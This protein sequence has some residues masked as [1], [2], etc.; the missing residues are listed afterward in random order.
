MGLPTLA[1][2]D[3]ERLELP[4]RVIA[5]DWDGTAVMGR[6]EDAAEVC[7]LLVR[8]MRRDVTIVVITGTNLANTT[9]QLA[10]A[11]RDAGDHN[12]RLFIATNRGSE[13]YGFDGRG[14]PVPRFRRTASPEE[15][16]RLTAAVEAVRDQLRDRAGIE[17]RIVYDRLNRRKIDLIPLPEWA[18]PPKPEIGRLLDA[19]QSRLFAGGITGGLQEVLR[20]S[21]RAAAEAGLRDARVTSDVKHVEIGLTDKS[22][23]VEWMM[24]EVCARERV[25]PAQVLIA[26][27]EFGPIGGVEGSDHKMLTPGSREAVF[28]SVGP[29]PGGV[30]P[31]IL[32][33]GGGPARFRELLSEQVDFHE[34]RRAPRRE[35][36]A[37]ALLPLAA[38][39]TEADWTIVGEGLDLAREREAESVFAVGNGYLGTRA[40]LAERHSLASSPATFVAGV[41]DSLPSSS[42]VPEFAVAP[43]WTK[44][45]VSVEGRELS[46]ATGTTLEHRRILDLRQGVTWRE[47]VQKD[48]DGRITRLRG[49]RLA[50]LSDRHVLLQALEVTPENWS[51]RLEVEAGIE[52]ATGVVAGLPVARPRLLPA[53]DAGGALVYQSR[54]GDLRL[55]VSSAS[56]LSGPAATVPELRTSSGPGTFSERWSVDAELGQT[57]RL[58]RLATVFTTRDGRRPEEQS[59]RHL[60]QAAAR[61]AHALAA[62]H[63]KAWRERWEACAVEVEGDRA[64][65]RNLRFAAYHLL[66][67]V[68]PEDERVSIGARTLTG[69]SYK[70]HVFWDTDIFIIPFFVFTWPEAARAL[71]AYRHHTLDGARKKA[72][73]AGYRGAL[74]AWE[75]ADTGEETTPRFMVAPDGEV[76]PILSGVQEHHISADVAYAVWGYWEA[77]H[78]ERFL[79]E[80]GAEILLETARFWESRG[81]WGEDGRFHLRTLIGP[82]EYHEGIDDNAFTNR[83]ARW[84][85]ERA[86]EVRGLLAQRWPEQLRSLEKRLAVTADEL[87]R[88]RRAAEA[89]AFHVDRQ[90]GVIE[91]F[92]GFFGLEDFDLA[93]QRAQGRASAPMDM[94]L[95]RERTQRTK[96]VKQS[97]VVM[98]LQLLWDELAPEVRRANYLYYEPRTCHGSSLS[99]GTHALVAAKLGEQETA[100]RYFKQAGEIDLANNMGNAAGGVH[101]A[102]LGGLWQA[103]VFGFGGVGVRGDVLVVD[104]RVPPAWRTLRFPLSFRGT[105]LVV[106]GGRGCGRGA[107]GLGR[108]GA[109]GAGR[110]GGQG[111]AAGSGAGGGEA[112][113]ALGARGGR[114]M[115]PEE[116]QPTRS[117]GSGVLPVAPARSLVV[118]LDGTEAALAAVR[119]ARVLARALGG[120]VHFVHV[121]SGRPVPLAQ[122]VGELRLRPGELVGGIVE[123]LAGAPAEQILAFADVL[124]SPLV[125]MCAEAPDGPGPVAG[126][127]IERGSSPVVLIKPQ[128]LE[129]PWSLAHLLLPHDGRSFT[130]ASLGP[131]M[132]LAELAGAQVTVLHVASAEAA[133]VLP[134]YEDQVQHEWPA[135]TRQFLERTA[136]TAGVAL[137]PST[138]LALARG[139]AGPE[140]VRFAAR[141]EV[142]LV[143]I[144]GSGA[145]FREVLR[146]CSCPVMTLR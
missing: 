7:A 18:D 102:A 63:A 27:D 55:S 78:D 1:G 125:V 66:C 75:S 46:V 95:G 16:A 6:K 109:G 74:Y 110:T 12:R 48:P 81:N 97:D 59:S 106:T 35:E 14:K 136:A 122:L 139:E 19:V 23:S 10:P 36:A 69:E 94:L 15:E 58:E 142:D 91:Q 60:A 51:G 145:A 22:D 100:L 3:L 61:G 41:F 49:L 82:D 4:F 28:V 112:G 53:P 108:T 87:V 42:A 54:R 57:Y 83:M 5:F 116:L 121:A 135:W 72:K 29:E 39:T 128:R 21:E 137:P 64:A 38:P 43:D 92:A 30:E 9:Y 62:E 93:P 146:R 133:D 47:W 37:Q 96:I 70:G 8:L 131:A 113:R 86:L 11:I 33:L 52:T 68:T 50:S 88:W 123:E 79:V 120:T 103:A 127:V 65:Q 73:E 31:V 56:K 144:A 99:P 141:H 89:M 138:E 76:I 85:L 105:R 134:A 77:T 44:L 67:A 124:D 84:N 90:T 13:V 26:G 119:V 126:A 140:I 32:H 104:P 40:A 117:A 24:R 25:R 130:G 107:V 118:P 132:E 34:G 115:T 114:P 143:G 45:K 80:K 101:A 17:A 20:L 98:L 129:A 2:R 111:G 71:L